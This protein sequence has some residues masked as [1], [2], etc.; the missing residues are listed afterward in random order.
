VL[1][2]DPTVLDELSFA[3]VVTHVHFIEGNTHFIIFK[4][5]CFR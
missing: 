5:L 4:C 3:F 1:N 2:V